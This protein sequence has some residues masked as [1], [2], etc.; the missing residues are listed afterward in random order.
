MAKKVAKPSDIEEWIKSR[1]AK[2]KRL[3]GG[4]V[5]V[6]EVPKSASGKI[7]RKT[8]REWAKADAA[9]LEKQIRARF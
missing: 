1:V 8:I 7:Q 6:D 9:V 3:V 5:F 4:V 2:H